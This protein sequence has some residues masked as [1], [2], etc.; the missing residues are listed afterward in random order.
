MRVSRVLS[1]PRL[2]SVPMRHLVIMN[3]SGLCLSCCK[4]DY[5][6]APGH[7]RKVSCDS[8]GVK[9]GTSGAIMT[10]APFHDDEPGGG[11]LKHSFPAVIFPLPF[12][13]LSAVDFSRLESRIMAAF[14]LP[15]EP[16]GPGRSA[17]RERRT[18]GQRGE[19]A[20][21]TA[22]REHSRLLTFG[23]AGVRQRHLTRLA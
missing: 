4:R 9:G 3:F 8:D 14:A 17:D 2:R 6:I 12:H 1:A 22:S 16:D 7:P 21:R 13:P 5:A 15:R 10:E 19:Q 23:R 20:A 11:G 18:A